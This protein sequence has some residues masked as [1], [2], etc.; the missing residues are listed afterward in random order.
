LSN[1]SFDE[2]AKKKKLLTLP[3]NMLLGLSGGGTPKN[4]WPEQV[5]IP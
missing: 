2:D 5:F 1:I 3:E 4:S